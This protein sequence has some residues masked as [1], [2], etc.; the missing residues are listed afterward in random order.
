MGRRHLHAARAE[1]GIHEAVGYHRDL[2]TG[3]GQ[4]EEL[5]HQAAVALIIR[6]HSHGGVAQ[7]GLGPGGGYHHVPAAIRQGIAQVPKLALALFVLHFEIAEGGLQ[8]GIPLDHAGAA[9]DP[10][11][12]VALHKDM[13]HRLVQGRVQ[14]EAVAGPVHGAA[15]TLE[16]MLDGALVLVLPVPDA[17][18][19]GVPAQLV[20]VRA[21]GLELTLH[22]HLGGDAGVIR[23]RHPQGVEALG[24]LE[25]GEH[26]VEGVHQ[27]VAH[28][29]VAGDV[30]RRDDD[31]PGLLATVRSRLEGL[32]LFPDLIPAQL[33]RPEVESLV[34]LAHGNP[35]GPASVLARPREGAANAMVPNAP[36][37]LWDCTG[38]STG[39]CGPL[40]RGT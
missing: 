38:S 33:R 37:Y 27:G 35:S 14:G 32:R 7:H 25:A 29:Q 17:L 22:H 36:V 16:L 13:A 20:A 9:E 1:G 2:A 10:A 15:Q 6:V 40:R 39:P 12:L 8:G 26:V 31:G 21:L 34:H 24:A 23:A 3:E 19:E 4:V 11:R 5:A 30:R 28:V 18:L